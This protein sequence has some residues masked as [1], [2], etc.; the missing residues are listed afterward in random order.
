M[1]PNR[2]WEYQRC[3]DC[4]EHKLWRSPSLFDPGA[5]LWQVGQFLKEFQ[6][7]KFSFSS[8]DSFDQDHGLP[9]FCS[10]GVVG[11]WAAQVQEAE[12]G[13]QAEALLGVGG[14]GGAA[15]VVVGG[16]SVVQISLCTF[17]PVTCS[18]DGGQWLVNETRTTI[19][20]WTC[21]YCGILTIINWAIRIQVFIF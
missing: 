16:G 9:S 10:L 13:F 8:T 20:T 2:K 15:V 6:S 17:C 5:Q 1:S 21:R 18:T 11:T 19:F 14:W 12:A 4:T 7:S 3:P